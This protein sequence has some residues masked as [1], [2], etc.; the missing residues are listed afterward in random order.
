MYVMPFVSPSML[1]H[2]SLPVRVVSRCE[3]RVGLSIVSDMAI[4]H[5]FS[6][7]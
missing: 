6:P 4:A 7:V 2:G 1:V 3:Y 5:P